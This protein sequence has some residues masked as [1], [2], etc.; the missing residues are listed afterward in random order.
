M[1]KFLLMSCAALAFSLPV[2]AQDYPTLSLK[3]VSAPIQ[4]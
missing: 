3:M 4:I 1:K 2:H